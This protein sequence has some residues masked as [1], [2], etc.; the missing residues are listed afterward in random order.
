MVWPKLVQPWTLTTHIVVQWEGPIG[1]DGAPTKR[2]V[3][4]G[5][6]NYSEAARQVMSAE[7]QLV[8]LE[9]VALFDGDICPGE[10]IRGTVVVGGDTVRTIYRSSRGRN[11]DGTVNFTR[12][13]L[14]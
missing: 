4:D 10:D 9:A 13:D 11:P 6:C 8:Q 3:Y 5:L 1:E 2:T 12:L 7:R 14:M